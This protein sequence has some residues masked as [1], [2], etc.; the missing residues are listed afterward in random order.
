MV[1]N[2]R[3]SNQLSILSF[4]AS[5]SSDHHLSQLEENRDDAISQISSPTIDLDSDSDEPSIV[6]NPSPENY[7]AADNPGQSQDAQPEAQ[8]STTGTTTWNSATHASPADPLL[9]LKFHPPSTYKFPKRQF[10]ASGEHYDV[11]SDAAFCYLCM[12][13]EKEGKLLASTR[14]EPAFISKGFT[15]WKEATTAFNKHQASTCHKEANE[16]INLLP[17]QLLGNVDDLMSQ[18][19]QEHKANNRKML[20]KILQNIRFLAR[21]G[22]SLRSHAEADN[23]FLQLFHLR[24]LDCPLVEPWMKK[25][26]DKYLS[27][28]IQNECLL[29]LS[30]HILRSVVSKIRESGC[31]T[32]MADECSDVSNKE[33]LTI[34]IRWVDKHLKDHESFIGLYQVDGI[35]ADSLTHAIKVVLTQI[36]LD[37]SNCRGQCY[38]RASNMS[39]SKNGVASQITRVEKRALYMHCYGHALNLAVGQ[40]VKQSKICCEALEVAFEIT[41]LIKF[42]P[43]RNALFDRIKADVAEEDSSGVGIRTFCP[44]RWTVRGNSIG[45]ILENFNILTQLWEEC[46]E[47]KLDPDI[48]GRIIG[49]STQMSK[50]SLIFGL[51]LCEKVLKITDNLSMTLQK[52]SL[53]AAQAQHV[54][55]LTVETLKRMRTCESFENFFQLVEALQVKYKADPPVLPRKRK[56]PRR[57]EIG[58][59]ECYFSDDVK[60][61]Y[62]IQYYEVLDLAVSGISD[63]FDQPGYIMHSKLES[64]VIK[65]VNQ[66]DYSNE[67]QSVIA[68]YEEDFSKPDLET[69]LEI[70]KSNFFH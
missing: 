2:R 59:G 67:L 57:I 4:V 23:N 33:Q 53:S 22:L 63:R 12:K 65:A 50:Y 16:A 40:T 61:Y 54:A 31:F 10:G 55:Q 51:K 64:L 30:S 39:G 29:L 6:S 19:A 60:D 11:S 27:H 46:L 37:L 42:S 24:G 49:V 25:K 13:A 9:P 41:K 7:S 45:A 34:C 32:I 17:N 38:D 62:R 43:R 21:Q 15:Y 8:F 18:E 69:Q 44:T 3:T 58:E 20:M 1:N 47:L 26:S 68:F 70:L 5:T 35:T 56:A 48:K 36:A 14:R 28:A 52:Q 66:E